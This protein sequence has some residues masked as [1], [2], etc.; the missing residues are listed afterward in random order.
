MSS[1]RERLAGLVAKSV[2]TVVVLASAED[3]LCRRQHC[4]CRYNRLQIAH[5]I[6]NSTMPRYMA[7]GCDT[8]NVQP[9][10]C[11]AHERRKR[12]LRRNVWPFEAQ[13]ASTDG[14]CGGR[15]ASSGC[16]S[17]GG[18]PALALPVAPR[19]TCPSF[20]AS[21]SWQVLV[22]IL[23]G[24]SADAIVATRAGRLGASLVVRVLRRVMC[25]LCAHVAQHGGPRSVVAAFGVA[26]WPASRKTQRTR[27]QR[28]PPVT[29]F[30]C[31][32]RL[33]WGLRI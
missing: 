21:P 11:A 14:R 5:A 33:R 12:N 24:S 19:R 15:C 6:A 26:D 23:A 3:L 32:R 8:A 28:V 29:Q 22:F 27:P 31:G 9:N 10:R 20:V 13:G 18:P 25:A 17:R 16:R 7:T 4:S 1:E 30:G 2:A